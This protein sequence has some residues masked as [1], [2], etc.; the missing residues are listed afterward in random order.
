M[1]YILRVGVD[2]LEPHPINETIYSFNQEQQNELKKSISLLGLIEPITITPRNQV[3]SGH[4]RLQQRYLGLSFV[5]IAP[6]FVTA[7]RDSANATM[8]L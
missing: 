1:N 5:L 8:A 3:L 7:Q 6:R 2:K 4:R